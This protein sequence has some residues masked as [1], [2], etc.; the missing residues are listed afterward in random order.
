[1]L[2]AK[3]KYTKRELKQ[4]KFVLAT[5]KA[6]SFIAIMLLPICLGMTPLW[7]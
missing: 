7:I 1:M 6:K 3:K 2:K 4:D 5:M